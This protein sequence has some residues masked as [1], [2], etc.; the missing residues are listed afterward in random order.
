MT[1]AQ[2]AEQIRAELRADGE[3]TM[4]D[5]RARGEYTPELATRIWGAISD[6]INRQIDDLYRTYSLAGDDWGPWG[7]CPQRDVWGL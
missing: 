5:L 6:E 4:R 7:G 2:Q 1:L 3:E